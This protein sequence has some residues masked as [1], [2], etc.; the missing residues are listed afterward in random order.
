M[1]PFYSCPNCKKEI[2]C[3]TDA[4]N[5]SFF[6]GWGAFL[7]ER[8]PF[9]ETKVSV[10]WS[11]YLLAILITFGIVGFSYLVCSSVV[12]GASE[13][14]QTVIGL[15]LFAT[16]LPIGMIFFYIILPW[17]FGRIGLNFYRENR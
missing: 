1:R 9:C 5:S 10:N 12:S 4:A 14:S 8:C 3:A 13:K 16:F 11:H 7:K 2:S 17:F 15:I 6:S